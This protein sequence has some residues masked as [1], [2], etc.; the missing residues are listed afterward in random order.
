MTRLGFQSAAPPITGAGPMKRRR[1]LLP[2]GTIA[3]VLFC[4]TALVSSGGDVPKQKEPVVGKPGKAK[5]DLVAKGR[6]L[7]ALLNDSLDM[8]DFQAPMTLKEALQL[9]QKHLQEKHR[10]EDVFPVLVD[11]EAFKETNP[12]AP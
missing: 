7:R 2:V 6:R 3:L 1:V 9:I 11:A 8:S 10:E 4:L 12:A 5:A